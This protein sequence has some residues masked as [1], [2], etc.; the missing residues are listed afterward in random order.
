MRDLIKQIIPG[1]PN[2]LVVGALR[3]FSIF[4]HISPKT[5]KLHIKENRMSEPEGMIENQREL[6]ALS[7]GSTDMAYA[8][9]E[10]IAVYNALLTVGKRTFLSELIEAFEKR[11]TVFNGRFGTSPYALAGYLKNLGIKVA[12]SFKRKNFGEIAEKSRVFI[13][14]IY[15]DRKNIMQQVH[16]ICVTKDENG[17]F[18]PHNCGCGNKGF[19]GIKELEEHI[20][21]DGRG[22]IF[23]IIGLEA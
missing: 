9:C 21:C 13:V 14:T 16:T 8:G 17:L 23:Y 10:V 2:G 22:R 7:F 5:R 19:N 18:V 4:S 1:L 20:G 11:G 6:K 3:F 12:S 15:N